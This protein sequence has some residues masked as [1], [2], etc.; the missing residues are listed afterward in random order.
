MPILVN[1]ILNP[2]IVEVEIAGPAPASKLFLCSGAVEFQILPP[3]QQPVV[4][5]ETLTFPIQDRGVPLTL[6]PADLPS[7][8]ILDSTASV[9][10][11][12]TRPLP[13][14]VLYES[15]VIQTGNMVFLSSALDIQW[16]IPPAP[17]AVVSYQANL[18]AGPHI[19]HPFLTLDGDAFIEV[20][21]SEVSGDPHPTTVGTYSISTKDIQVGVISWSVSPPSSNTLIQT[22][23]QPTTGIVF[24]ITGNRLGRGQRKTVTVLVNGIYSAHLP[25]S[26]HEVREG[27]KGTSPQG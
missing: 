27:G 18:L 16:P 8:D 26:I 1:S 22:D 13:E 5:F 10:L 24:D 23:G 11:A 4:E 3:E 12:S 20:A 2:R 19:P 25:V 14:L 17:Q 9:A 15:R 21:E 6:G 7:L